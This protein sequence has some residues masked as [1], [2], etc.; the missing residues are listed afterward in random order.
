MC[1]FSDHLFALI[2]SNSAHLRLCILMG[3]GG[4]VVE[5]EVGGLFGGTSIIGNMRG[6][7]SILKLC[8]LR[9][10]V[11]TLGPTGL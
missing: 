9:N 6:A 1:W 5:E 8:A 2:A 4:G 3:G 11:K 7:D 10:Y